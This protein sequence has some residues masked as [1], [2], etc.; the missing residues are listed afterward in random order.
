MGADRD[1]K[2][3]GFYSH[4]QHGEEAPIDRMLEPVAR[5]LRIEAVSGVLLL[6]CAA[7]AML[8]A[9]SPWR[10][11]VD[12]FWLADVGFDV[13]EAQFHLS[14]LHWI[15]D[16]LMTVFFFV[17][18]L[19]IKREIVIGE[20]R[21]WRAA[22][23]PIAAALGGMVA[24]ALVFLSLQMGTPGEPGWGVPMATDIA[25]VVGVLTVLGRRVPQSLKLFL[26]TLAIVDDLGAI[27]VIAV[28]YSGAVEW[29]W[30]ALGVF[31]V[32]VVVALQRLGVWSI[33]AYAVA[34]A[35]LWYGV[36]HSGLHPTIAGVVLG[37]ATPIVGR[38]M[39]TRPFE[40]AA[41][42]VRDMPIG[43]EAMH[44][45]EVHHKLQTLDRLIELSRSPLQRLEHSL[46]GWVA[47]VVMP[48]FALANAGVHLHPSS[49][50]E[51]LAWAVAAGLVVGKPLGILAASFLVARVGLARLPTDVTWLILLGGACLAGI[52]F[53][54][55]LFV[56]HL[57][58]QGDLLGT[59]K[60]GVLAGSVAS[61]L[62]GIAILVFALGR[63]E[64]S[65]GPNA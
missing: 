36:Y 61:G 38:L 42:H 41:M 33:P 11:A 39:P 8:L 31:G 7:V 24:P 25:F 2:F 17:V 60:F 59:A 63:K 37:L 49:L 22:V 5:F 54:M 16:G 21:Q 27:L 4:L 50:F 62:L 14:L 46:H 32:A 44:N 15:N 30:L 6:I 48:L 55:S 1:R 20:L 26:L 47:F 65:T 56:S 28:F 12:R 35:V 3:R 58:F 45:P 57:A 40:Y 53:T 34:G 23:L 64:A 51:P 13:G 19:E 52:G 10:E 18:G 43:P 9:N 29:G